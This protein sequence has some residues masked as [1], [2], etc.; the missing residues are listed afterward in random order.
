MGN[1]LKPNERMEK[2]KKINELLVNPHHK[3]FK[4]SKSSEKIQLES[5]NEIRQKWGLEFEKFQTFKGRILPKPQIFFF[6]DM[7]DNNEKK[8]GKIQQQKFYQ[9][10]NLEKDIWLILSN[11]R[12]NG[13]KAFENLVKC[14]TQTGITIE[15]PEIMELKGK[16][17]N[18]YIN[19]LR[20]IDLNQGKKIVLI[21]LD[22]Y[23]KKY[24]PS[25]KNWN[26]FSMYYLGES[27]ITKFIILV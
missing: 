19:K 9:S 14:S 26:S 10:I 1:I 12:A 11:Y 5:P 23:S 18:E 16:N 13:E 17:D 7:K 8:D 15:K 24:Y 4:K 22:N 21:I 27:E 25:I 6:N 20:T 2:I 3:Y